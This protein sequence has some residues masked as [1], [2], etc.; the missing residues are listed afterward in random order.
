MRPSLVGLV[1][2]VGVVALAMLGLSPRPAGAT[3]A[4]DAERARRAVVVAKIGETPITV[5]ELE[6]RLA[7]VPRFQLRD[8][9]A[10]PE[11]IRRGF[12]ERIVIPE[13]LL[14]EGA[15]ASRVADKAPWVGQI[16]RA[17]SGAALRAVRAQVPLGE[18]ITEADVRAYY[19]KNLSFYDSPERIHVFR[20]LVATQAE[21]EALVA[22]LKKDLTL[23]AFTDL[24]RD[25]N[26]D[27]ATAMRGGNLGFLGPDGA[28]NE[29]GLKADPALVVAAKTV[30]D[31]EL[32]PKPVA[33]GT[34]FA[35][36][37]R[38]GT[39]AATKKTLEEASAQIRDT[40]VRRKLEE[41][42]R[43]HIDEL[44]AK[45][46]SQRDDGPLSVFNVPVD[47]GPLVP[48]SDAAPKR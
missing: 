24:S 28:S 32:V 23:K 6:S 45:H 9:G 19:D 15:K 3:A 37:W 29:A 2:L 27:K 41:A 10:T 39:V 18:A 46:V 34:S 38:R 48:K 12:L 8:F 20:I 1:G 40:L 25:K 22:T 42:T 47:D 17:K 4:E 35:V 13:V 31:G 14:A 5:G 7:A 33:E 30:R 43:S 36:V 21:A 16:A 11:E 26:L 44:K